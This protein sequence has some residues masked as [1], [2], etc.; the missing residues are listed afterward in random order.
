MSESNTINSVI[1]MEILK[2]MIISMLHFEHDDFHW[3]LFNHRHSLQNACNGLVDYYDG[4]PNKNVNLWYIQ[5]YGCMQI[6]FEMCL[7]IRGM[8]GITMC[9]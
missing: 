3:K 5:E 1:Q 7:G 8:E 6:Y 2:L 4:F 9:G